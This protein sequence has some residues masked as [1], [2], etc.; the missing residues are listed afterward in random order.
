MYEVSSHEG[1]PEVPEEEKV[2]VV[3]VVVAVVVVIVVVVVVV[4]VVLLVVVVVV[5]VVVVVVVVAVRTVQ[6]YAMLFSHSGLNRTSCSSSSFGPAHIA[7]GMSGHF[8]KYG[9]CH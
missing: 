9:C 8:S 3:V 5:A 4:I 7:G 6:Y 2:V 1:Q